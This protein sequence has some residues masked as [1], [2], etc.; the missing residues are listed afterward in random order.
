MKKLFLGALLALLFA[1]MAN[2]LDVVVSWTNPTLN[3]DGTS[4]PATGPGALT[5]TRVEWG[6]CSATNVFGVKAGE[7]IVLSPGTSGTILAL[8]AGTTACFRAYAKNNNGV[9]SAPSAVVSKSIPASTPNAPVMAT[10]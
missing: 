1:P 2:A 3:T 7:I 10:P 8:P 5:Q 6:S 9:E 4:I